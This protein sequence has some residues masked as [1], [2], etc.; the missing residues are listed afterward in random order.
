MLPLFKWQTQVYR[1]AEKFPPGLSDGYAP[2]WEVVPFTLTAR[3]TQQ[4]RV[5]VQREFH[6]L[7]L[8]GSAT[9]TTNGGFRAQLYDQKKKRRFADRG[10]GFNVLTGPGGKLF[11]LREPYPLTE[12]SA[13]I[14]VVCQNLETST[15]TVQ[16]LLYGVAR[17]FNFPA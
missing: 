9:V 3:T 13:Q 12:E 15:N 4:A 14:L 10:V 2:I 1:L 8:G 5:N 16:I 17:R 6:L 7:A 11:F